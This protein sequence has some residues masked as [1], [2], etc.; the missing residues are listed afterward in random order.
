[1]DFGT[2][3]VIFIFLTSFIALA[4]SLRIVKQY[5]KGLVIRLGK[6]LSTA[7]SGVVILMPFI[8]SIIMIDMREQVINVDPQQVITRDNVS[9][10][11]DAVIYY[12]VVDPVKAEFE[13]ENFNY[14]ATTLA[15]TNLR[16][17]IG[18]KSLDETLTAR[19]IIN[20]NLRETLDEATNAWGVKITKV[21]LQKI[22]PPRDITEAMSRQMKAER[23]KRATILEAQ[24]IREAEILRAEGDAKAK[25]LRADAEAK[26]VKMV[27]QAAEKNFTN[28]AAKLKQLEV[29]TKVLGGDQTKFILPTGGEIVNVLNLD[30]KAG[31]VIPMPKK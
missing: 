27:A 18:D 3:F 24:G 12:K 11:V 25:I 28:R 10:V 31:N 4:K 17:L 20:T 1:M 14:A 26:A 15:Q 7:D 5:E 16:N 6:Y 13:I 29:A 22:D 9:V 23:G 19:D 30:G 2:M 21:E 8:D